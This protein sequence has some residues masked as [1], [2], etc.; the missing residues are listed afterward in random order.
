MDLIGGGLKGGEA[1]TP[2]F[3]GAGLETQTGLTEQTLSFAEPD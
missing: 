2:G 1:R 3:L